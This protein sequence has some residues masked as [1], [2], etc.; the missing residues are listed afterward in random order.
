MPASDRALTLTRL[1]AAAAAD[2][3]AHDVV[4]LDVSDHLVITDV[5]LICSAPNDRQVRAIVDAV[6]EKLRTEEHARPIRREGDRE[7]RW[8]LLDYADIVVHVQHSQER[9][10]YSLERLWRDCPPVPL[11]DIV[12]EHASAAAA[13]GVGA[14]SGAPRPTA[15][16]PGAYDDLWEPDAGSDGTVGDQLPD[17]APTDDAPSDDDLSDDE[18]PSQGEDP[19]A[20]DIVGRPEESV[21]LGAAGLPAQDAAGEVMPDEPLPDEGVPDQA[22]PDEELAD[23]QLAGEELP[24]AELGRELGRPELGRAELA[25]TPPGDDP[26]AD[27]SAP[28]RP[29]G[30]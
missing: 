19:A 3:L 14:D 20:G 2:R 16:D 13:A 12:A 28:N 23:E 7:S 22:L 25:D 17:D 5:F 21:D 15:P 29:H 8:V 6:E 24:G 9:E 11:G 30:A 27:L 18:D 26:D 10:F 4:A 1:A